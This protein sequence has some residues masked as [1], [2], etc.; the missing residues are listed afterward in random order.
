MHV[1]IP[2]V[3]G[4]GAA[5]ADSLPSSLSFVSL[6]LCLLFS[7]PCCYYLLSRAF[8]LTSCEDGGGGDNG[9][10]PRVP[11][12]VHA[13]RKARVVRKEVVGEL[14]EARVAAGGRTH[15]PNA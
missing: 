2:A 13:N 12:R 14:H 8:D 11:A 4:D 15:T 5:V 10:R 3:S 1:S 6:Q 9:A 7:F